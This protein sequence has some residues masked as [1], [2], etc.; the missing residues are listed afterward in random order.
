MIG[1]FS[2]IYLKIPFL[3]FIFNIFY[4]SR[5]VV[6]FF[7]FSFFILFYFFRLCLYNINSNLCNIFNV[8]SNLWSI[9][10][11]W[12]NYFEL[13]RKSLLSMSFNKRVYATSIAIYLVE[14][15]INHTYSCQI[16]LHNL[17]STSVLLVKIFDFNIR[18]SSV[19]W[20]LFGGN[21]LKKFALRKNLGYKLFEC[22]ELWILQCSVW[23]LLSVYSVFKPI[24][25]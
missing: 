8:Y 18:K 9:N 4:F 19:V 2:A 3:A 15:Q 20:K 16:G 14:S 5:Y 1:P 25:P 10:S 6:F 12:C 22:I 21:T 7:F 17:H 24:T 23:R 11:K 13:F